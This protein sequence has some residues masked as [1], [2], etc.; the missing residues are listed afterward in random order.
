L[1]LLLLVLLVLLV[2]LLLLLLLY[3]VN[4]LQAGLATLA[5]LPK[6]FARMTGLLNVLRVLMAAGTVHVFGRKFTYTRR[7][8]PTPARLKRSWV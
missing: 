6:S 3:I 1:L 8:V 4:T 2:L 5:S 7:L